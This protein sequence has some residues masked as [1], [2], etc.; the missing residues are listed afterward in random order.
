MLVCEKVPGV[1]VA[2]CL[3]HSMSSRWQLGHA[4]TKFHNA[5]CT[6]VD[7]DAHKGIHL[8][9]MITVLQI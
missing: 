7:S 1:A 5:Q 2:R 6:K 8:D 9:H 3:C 4:H